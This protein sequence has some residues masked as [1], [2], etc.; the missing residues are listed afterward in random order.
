V[1]LARGGA[2]RTSGYLFLAPLFTVILSYFAF[3]AALSWPQAGG[4]LLIGVALWL[5]NREIPARTGRERRN[6]AMAEGQY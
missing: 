2:T 4:G 5:V 6:E 1:A 3:D